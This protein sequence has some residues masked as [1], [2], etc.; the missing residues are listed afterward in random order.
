MD[1]LFLSIGAFIIGYSLDA[2]L[3]AHMYNKNPELFFAR[4]KSD[5][6]KNKVRKHGSKTMMM[7]GL[8][9]RY[10]FS[11]LVI[12]MIGGLA[13]MLLFSLSYETA[14]SIGFWAYGI[15]HFISAIG[16]VMER[17][18]IKNGI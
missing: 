18:E 15:E 2:L 4:E 5:Y 10:I 11:F 14:F 12:E 17:R 8:S 3:K 13:L 16:N 9:K 1:V 7:I 6:L